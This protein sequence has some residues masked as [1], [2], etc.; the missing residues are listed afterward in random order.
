MP[1]IHDYKC[2]ECGHVVSNHIGTLVDCSEC[3]A[4]A[5][6]TFYGNWTSI[7]LSGPEFVP[8]RLDDDTVLSTKAER[9]AHIRAIEQNTGT[10]CVGIVDGGTKKQKK[11]RKEERK[12]RGVVNRRKAGYC[13]KDHSERRAEIKRRKQE[14]ANA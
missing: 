7:G 8:L 12:H 5:M 1:A 10:K 2:R 6:E 9:D 14:A 13:E 3:G 4:A 11:A